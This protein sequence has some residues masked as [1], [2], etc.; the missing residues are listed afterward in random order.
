MVIM[1]SFLGT[2][3]EEWSFSA[4]SYEHGMLRDA[5]NPQVGCTLSHLVFL[6]R[7]TWQA[8]R[9]LLRGYRGSEAGCRGRFRP[10]W[11]P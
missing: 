2:A 1:V 8:F 6:A 7:Q 9:L 5:Q 11:E 4:A 3:H 10:P